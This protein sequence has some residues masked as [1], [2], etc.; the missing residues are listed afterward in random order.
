M[1]E[2]LSSLLGGFGTALS[3]MNLL[4]VVVGALL[5]TAVGVLPGLGS[6]MAVALLLPMTFTLDPTAAFIMFA[7]IYYGGMFGDS[8]SGILTNTP[9][10]SS[11]IATAIEGH[12]MALDGR[13]AQALATAAIGAFF[14]G[15]VAT[16][17][18]AFGAPVMAELASSFGPAEY[19]ALA[20]TAFVAIAAVVSDSF[21][22]GL[23]SLTLGLSIAL[24]GMDVMSGATR[25]T[26]GHPQLLDGVGVVLVT[27]ALLALGEV[28]H[29]CLTGGTKASAVATGKGR[30]R[31]TRAEFTKAVPAWLRGTGFGLPFGIIPVGGAEVPTF[32]AFGLEKRLDNKRDEPEFGT[33]AIRGVAAPEAASNATTGTA[34]GALLTLGLPVSATAAVMLAAFQQYGLQ[35]GPLLFERSPDLVWTLIASLFIG[36]VVLLVINLPFAPVWAKLLLIPRPYLYAGISLFAAFGVYALSS[37]TWDVAVMIAIGLVALLMRETGVPLAPFIIG[38]IL[39]PVAETELRRTLAISE[40]SV[41]GFFTPVSSAIYGVLLL[42][43]AGAVVSALLTRR[44]RTSA[45]TVDD[46]THA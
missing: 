26:A 46:R 17:V 38:V 25:F 29:V 27:V 21:V 33:G 32:L 9:G 11:A 40:G 41:T 18:V 7:G 15:V 43:V 19:L 31:L 42:V 34:M 45:P 8:T 37:S 22:K 30:V 12:R 6:S 39:G 20:L 4:W 1:L 10:Q 2:T 13:A 36:L 35:P 44:R 24:I 5:G 3:P 28:F 14:G 16:T 23:L